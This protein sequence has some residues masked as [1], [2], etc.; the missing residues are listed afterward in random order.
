[1]LLRLSVAAGIGILLLVGSAW[2]VWNK[3]VGKITPIYLLILARNAEP[4]CM[5]DC[6]VE[7]LY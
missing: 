2:A 7:I 5:K 4:K 1:M 6:I 3:S